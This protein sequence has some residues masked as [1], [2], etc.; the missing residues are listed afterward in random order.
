MDVPIQVCL[1]TYVFICCMQCIIVEEVSLNYSV[2]FS[3]TKGQYG[4]IDIDK[5]WLLGVSV[6]IIS[7]FAHFNRFSCCTR[8][9]LFVSPVL[10]S[11]QCRSLASYRPPHSICVSTYDS[12]LF[13]GLVDYHL[14]LRCVS[15]TCTAHYSNILAESCTI[16]SLVKTITARLRSSR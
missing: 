10:D 13:S 9:R 8:L 15:P 2:S 11:C 4:R 16:T 14:S 12:S 7:S 6:T 5:R 3:R 1:Y